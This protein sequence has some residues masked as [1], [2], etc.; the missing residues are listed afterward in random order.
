MRHE[1]L[2]NG[3]LKLIADNGDRAEMAEAYRNR[4]GYYDAEL[5]VH[6]ALR[7]V[8]DP[9]PEFY[10]LELGA[11]TSAPI[12]IEYFAVDD[13]DKPVFDG[14]VWWFPGYMVTDPYRQLANKGY[15]VFTV[16]Q[17]AI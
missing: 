12:W 14:A 2:A 11:L 16:A 9:V 10:Y 7:D 3:D 15:V 13:D 8:I 5:Y 1:V 4:N 6:D 17:D